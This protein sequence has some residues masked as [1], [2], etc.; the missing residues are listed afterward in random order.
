MST[1][2]YLRLRNLL[3]DQDLALKRVLFVGDVLDD[4]GTLLFQS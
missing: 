2:V 1:D 3:P 4:P